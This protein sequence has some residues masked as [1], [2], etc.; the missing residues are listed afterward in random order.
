MIIYNVAI[1]VDN[2][3]ADAWV[4]WMKHEHIADVLGT[5]LFTDARLCHLL[6][7]DESDGVT[8]I[9]QYFCSSMEQY[10]AYISD[11]ATAMREKGF[12]AFGG[13]FAAF[14]TIMEII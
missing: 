12:K 4:A 3:I 10:N 1:K 11:Y 14:R 2:D 5:G 6:E 7:Q 9:A 13:K 8:Y